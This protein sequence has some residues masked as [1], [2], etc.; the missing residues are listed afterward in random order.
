MTTEQTPWGWLHLTCT[1]NEYDIHSGSEKPEPICAGGSVV[2]LFLTPQKSEREK[3][4]EAEVVRLL[5][6]L[7]WLHK[8]LAACFD[9]NRIK[10]V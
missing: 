1:G 10:E 2:P 9:K 5:D 6:N 7:D 3:V 4:L 8:R